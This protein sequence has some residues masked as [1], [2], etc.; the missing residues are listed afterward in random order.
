MKNMIKFNIIFEI[1]NLVKMNEKPINIAYLDESPAFI[2]FLKNEVSGKNNLIATTYQF[3]KE[4]PNSRSGCI[5]L[6]SQ[7]LFIKRK[8][9][10]NGGV[11]RFEVNFLLK[12]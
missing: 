1:N 12:K 9:K 6:L 10:T 7:D 8:I 2:R 3:S 4:L 5:Y 11:F